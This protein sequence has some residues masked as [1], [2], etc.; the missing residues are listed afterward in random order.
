MPKDKYESPNPR[1]AHT[2]MSP[3]DAAAG[4]K[5]TWYELEITGNASHCSASSMFTTCSGGSGLVQGSSNPI[6]PQKGVPFPAARQ[7]WAALWDPPPSNP[8]PDPSPALEP[9]P[10]ISGRARPQGQR[11]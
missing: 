7:K 6:R 3:E 11:P 8:G 4:K 5:S 9:P 2:L 1:R 10:P